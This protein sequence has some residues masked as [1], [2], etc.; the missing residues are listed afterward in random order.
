MSRQTATICALD[1]LVPGRIQFDVPLSSLGTWR[2]GGPADALAEP[3]SL[4]EVQLVSSFVFRESL[5]YV[6]IG[7][8]SN[9]L[10]DDAGFRG[11]V[12][13]LGEG[14]SWVSVESSGRVSAGAA[15]WV[16]RFVRRVADAGLRGCEY[17]IGIPAS[18]GG[19]VVMN[20]GCQGQGIG[21]RLEDVTLV[22]AGGE[23]RSLRRAECGF[24]YRES[25]LQRMPCIVVD[26]S[27]R[28]EVSNQ[29]DIRRCMIAILRERRRKF[30]RKTPNCGSVFSSQP[31]LYAQSGPVGRLVELAG[32]KGV[33]RGNAVVSTLHANFILNLGR[34]SSADVLALI[35]DVRRGVLARTG[36]TLDT[37]V[38]YL[39]PNG[40]LRPAHEAAEEMETGR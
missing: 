1:R 31:E 38:L 9:I 10:F 36:V 21:D 4:E 3:Q 29:S 8:G 37:E 14:L 26:A 33:R 6:V 35:S 16:P 7:A 22:L 15:C 28:Y 11:L 5:P 12:I 30:P 39:A 32:F 34:A 40:G 25:L 13:R 17:A 20:G 23:S 18:L 27:F 2:I 24:A 19:L